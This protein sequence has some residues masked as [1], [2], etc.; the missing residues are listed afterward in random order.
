MIGDEASFRFVVLPPWYRSWWANILGIIFLL[1]LIN[2]IIR[3]RVKYL[4]N[5]NIILEKLITERTAEI[6]EQKLILQ[7]QAN[8]LLELDQI[9]SNFFANI[10]HEF[11][12]PL[13]TN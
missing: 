1:I 6:N 2:Y 4:N 11:R 9:K 7:K 8:Q 5:K 10:S 12:T 3:Y 13:Y